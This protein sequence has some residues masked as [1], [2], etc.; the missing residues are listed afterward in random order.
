MAKA[1]DDITVIEFASHSAC[2]YC[3]MLMAE[4]GA[5]VLRIEPPAGD[6][7]RGGPHYAVLNRS[8]RALALELEHSEGASAAVELVKTADL[9]LNGFSPAR[10]ESLDLSSGR[11]QA[12]N[13]RAIVLN[14]PPL[15]SQ[16]PYA[17]LT[18]GDELVSAMSGVTAAQG[19]LSGDPVP[20]AFP[21]VSYQTGILGALSA[22]A[23]LCWRDVTGEGQVVEVSML[24]GALS[25]QSGS[26]VR[27]PE[28]ISLMAANRR[29]PMGPA[30]SYRIYSGSDGKF[31][32]L[33]CVTP[34]FWNKLALAV[35]RP[36]L[37]S[38]PRFENAPMGLNPEQ[39]AALID[40]LTPIMS[41]RP[42]HEWLEILRSRDVPASPV[43]TRHEFIDDPQ[44]IH[45]RMRRQVA[46]P[47]L[48]ETV[49]MGV[50]IMLSD[51]RGEISGPAPTL[52]E[53]GPALET[54]LRESRRHRPSTGLEVSARGDS[55]PSWGPLAGTVVLDFTAYIAGSYTTMLLAH[56]GA[57]VVKVESPAGDGFRFAT[58][59]FQGWN[60]NKRG[61]ALDLHHERGREIAYALARRADL[62]VENFRPGNARELGIDYETLKAIN[63][64]IVYVSINGFGS[65]GPDFDHPSFDPV[66][67]ARSGVMAAHDG[68][69]WG[70][71]EIHPIVL[72]LPFCDYGGAALAALAGVLGRRHQRATGQ[73]QRCEVTLI[74]S[75]MALQAGEFVFYPGRPNLEC[76]APEFRGMSAL[77][78]VYRCQDGKW[79]C[80]DVSN[81]AQWNALQAALNIA[82]ARSFS[83]ASAEPPHGILAEE[84]AWQFAKNPLDAT[85]NSLISAGVAAAPVYRPVEVFDTAQVMANQLAVE[86]DHPEFGPISQNGVLMKFSATPSKIWSSAP[87]L[88][89]HT[90]EVLTEIGYT[91]DQIRELEESRIVLA[92]EPRRRDS[93][94]L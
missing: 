39:R 8:K 27:H 84:L 49:Q 69:A 71:G 63:P 94:R 19:S 93:H 22:T 70:R 87:I 43:L 26:I 23:A 47:L 80:L 46:D 60:Q 21:L 18:A 86:L 76:G 16:G 74:H 36:E 54:L 38:D 13:P 10:L 9:V 65:S 73:G 14:M 37:L 2:A 30:P 42:A 48:G 91:A 5:R 81:E 24:A 3:A 4:Q 41:S 52:E 15:G 82:A 61:I 78:R 79:I 1:L 12:I 67:Q 40:I 28:V 88:G 62:V 58:F 7:A 45:V 29:D 44:V 57:E 33:S 66:L 90:R 6:P 20:L 59:A 55:N 72:N 35:N 53:Y 83:A 50:P 68:S 32:M 51:T 11:I 17:E 56:L 34:T 31:L 64:R 75:A 25:L 85:L 77:R 92:R 89:Q